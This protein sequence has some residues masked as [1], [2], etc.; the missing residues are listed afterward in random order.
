[1]VLHDGFF[2]NKP[3]SF[4]MAGA[5]TTKPKAALKYAILSDYPSP[6]YLYDYQVFVKT[7]SYHIKTIEA[8][9]RPNTAKIHPT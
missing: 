3:I 4:C 7:S 6:P 9:K 1:M 8:S 5:K 2:Q